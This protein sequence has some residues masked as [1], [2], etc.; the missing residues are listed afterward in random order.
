MT[1]FLL[2]LV[3][4]TRFLPFG[5]VR[6][7]GSALGW[8]LYAL[9]GS[10]RRV[11]QTNLR[12]CFPQ[13]SDEEVQRQSRKTFV[14]FAQ[15]WLD[16]GWIWHGDPAIARKRIKLVGA[17]EEFITTLVDLDTVKVEV[18]V[19]E[20]YLSQVQVGLGVGFKVAAFPGETF[21]G[22]VY[23]I[24]P[25]LDAGTRTALVKAR[26]ANPGG[27]LRGGMFANL[28][29]ALELRKLALVIPEPAIM[30]N[31][32]TTMVFTVN[33]QNKAEMKPVKVGLR[34]AGRA[35]ILSGLT[36]GDRVV[37]EGVQ[38]L[39]PGAPVEIAGAEATAPYTK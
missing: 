1:R 22:E 27:R 26:I 5:V 8:L 33:A 35:E 38:K 24:S 10:R 6:A 30:N 9:V 14:Y 31:G 11:V 37:V 32:D 23:F 17:V 21:K 16:R 7:L 13:W 20:R 25:Q 4:W 18:S 29:L 36:A 39:R 28:D 3:E 34:L 15:A 2:T 12:L 19:P